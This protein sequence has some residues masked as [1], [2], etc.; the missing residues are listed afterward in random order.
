MRPRVNAIR[1]LDD[2]GHALA[3]AFRQGDSPYF[4]GHVS[5]DGLATRFEMADKNGRLVMTGSVGPADAPQ[6][7]DITFDLVQFT[8]GD[9]I[10]LGSLMGD[11]L[12]GLDGALD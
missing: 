9:I 10:R 3:V 12:N 8:R 2:D 5:R 7:F 11:D 1:F 4:L 6:V